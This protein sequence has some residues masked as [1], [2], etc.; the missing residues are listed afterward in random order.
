MCVLLGLY[1]VHTS[2]PFT[3]SLEITCTLFEHYLHKFPRHCTHKLHSWQTVSWSFA[4][5]T[6]SHLFKQ[7]MNAEKI[8]FYQL[9]DDRS[10]CLLNVNFFFFWFFSNQTL[11]H[12][13][14]SNQAFF[15][16]F[17]PMV[18]RCV[19]SVHYCEQFGA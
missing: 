7:R 18:I 19:R 4:F 5:H 10:S 11:I 17:E 15:L 1:I 12:S 13:F 6:C 8:A 14:Y 16:H 9:L 2:I 3:L